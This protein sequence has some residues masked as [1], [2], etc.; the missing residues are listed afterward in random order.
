[1]KD[2]T[3]VMDGTGVSRALARI[4]HEII[5][6]NNGVDDIC[7]L[8]I[9]RRGISLAEALASNIKKFEGKEVPLGTIDI[10]RHRDDISK[11]AKEELKDGC[12]IPFDI[13]GK[14]VV[15]V[16]DVLFTGRTARAAME[17]VFAYGRPRKIQFAVLVDRGHRELP[18]RADYVGKNMPTSLNEMVKVKVDAFDRETGVYIGTKE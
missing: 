4:T 7:L 3:R 8:G 2:G 13:T 11:T 9:K 12:H 17:A 18:I 16:D 6:R 1:M 15:M 14:T 5:E 10:T